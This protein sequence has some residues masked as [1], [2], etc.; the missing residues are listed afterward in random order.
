M[1]L[2]RWSERLA[3]GAAA[4]LALTVPGPTRAQTNINGQLVIPVDEFERGDNDGNDL[5]PGLLSS[6]GERARAMTRAQQ[7]GVA[8]TNLVG[9]PI[10]WDGRGDHGRGDDARNTQVND[11]ALDH[12]QTFPGTRPFE[13]SIE[14]ETSLVNLG[15]DQIVGYNSSAGANVALFGTTPGVHAALLQRVLGLA[16]R[17]EDLEERLPAAGVAGLALHLRRPVARRRPEGQ[18]LLREPGHR[19]SGQHAR[20]T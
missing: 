18:R 3:L 6:G 5:K 20:S 9:S 13:F 14:S 16:R 11:P 4:A 1:D 17:R 19:P 2:R 8:R 15:R 12:I 7:D 10:R